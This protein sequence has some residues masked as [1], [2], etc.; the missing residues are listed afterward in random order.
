MTNSFLRGLAVTFDW[1]DVP[2]AWIVD[3]AHLV[4]HQRATTP[5]ASDVGEHAM[6]DLVPLA[7]ARWEVTHVDRHP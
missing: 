6:F 3:A 4:A 5:V 1:S 7:R 2:A